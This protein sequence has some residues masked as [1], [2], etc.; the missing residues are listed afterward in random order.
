M[1]D[2]SSVTRQQRTGQ[3]ST[4]LIS[5]SIL[6]T[7]KYLGALAR[8]VPRVSYRWIESCC[9]AV[10]PSMTKYPVYKAPYESNVQ[11]VSC[12]P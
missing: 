11:F 2:F 1:D 6:R 5:Y 4:F 9:E 8:N 12:L 7:P 3:S 10:S